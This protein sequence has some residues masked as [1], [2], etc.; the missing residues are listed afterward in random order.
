MGPRRAI[1]TSSS[2]SQGV[3]DAPGSLRFLKGVGPRRAAEFERAGLRSQKDLLARFPLRYEDRSRL[4]QST[5]LKPGMMASLCGEVVSMGLRPTRRRGFN[6]FEMLARDAAGS[7]RIVW[8]NQPFLQEVFTEG[9]QVTFFGRVEWRHSGGLRLTNPQF[10]LGGRQEGAGK[11]GGDDG[12]RL[13]MGRIVPVYERIGSLTP[14]RLRI[15]VHEALRQ[16]PEPLFDPLPLE[17]RAKYRWPERRDALWAAHFPASDTSLDELNRFRA[18]AQVRLIYEE[19][20]LLQFGLGLRRRRR[21]SAT[22]PHRVLING[23][24]RQ[25]ALGVLPFRLTRGQKAALRAVVDDMCDSSPM[26]RLLQGDVGCGKT[27]VALLAALVAMENGLQVAFMA[28]T[29]LLAEQHYLSISR[30][31]GSSGFSV[32]ALTG[33]MG[34]KERRDTLAAVAQG[35]AHL[36]V[37]T[38]ALVQRT[39]RFQRLGLAVIDEQHR[40]GVLQRVT[41][42]DKGS[43]PDF[44]VMT[45]TPIP[46]TLALTSYGDL[47]I[48]VIRDLPPGRVPVKTTLDP[49]S[50]REQVYDLVGHQLEAGRQAYVVYP[51]IEESE[52]L[53]LKAATEMAARLTSRFPAHSVGLLHGRMKA[54]ERE[55]V[56]RRFA[57]GETDLLVSTTVIEV[58]VDVPNATVMVVEHAER[59]GL[60][61]LHQ[62]RGRVGRGRD[63][64]YCRLLHQ[65]R[66]SL[67]A[68]SRLSAMVETADGF[69]IAE[70]DLQQRGPGEI[71]GTR[72]SGV[73]V[74]RVADLNRDHEFL[75]LARKEAEA[76]LRNDDTESLRA[77]LGAEWAERFGLVGIG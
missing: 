29:E 21:A 27:I 30:L 60:A 73:P 48:S 5:D 8:I 19:L 16:L 76:L 68:H 72:Q 33:G 6:V 56:M 45:A 14:K 31:L 1:G 24:V 62:L 34:A 50:R 35:D 10:E 22:K 43:R 46:R 47:D 23:E 42:R 40:F 32:V 37:G 11:L 41:L 7:F 67:P 64:A 38:H 55:T 63:Q 59:F 12:E 74:L 26:H 77:C 65:R 53:D 20:F 44:L 61:Q 70:R 13:D 69:E 9:Q 51:L 52:K 71:L 54:D 57:G 4:Q 25:S 18:P 49:D 66:L 17:L 28:P 58:G 2:P 15:L 36:V 3:A 75:E 39:V